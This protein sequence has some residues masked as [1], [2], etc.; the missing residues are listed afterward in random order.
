MK[1]AQFLKKSAISVIALV[2]LMS[3][4]LALGAGGIPPESFPAAD[5]RGYAMMWIES[6]NGPYQVAPYRDHI[7]VVDFHF[8]I[9][10]QGTSGSAGD[11]YS[12]NPQFTEITVVKNIDKTSPALAMLCASGRAIQFVEIKLMRTETWP[13][14]PAPDHYYVFTLDDVVI[15]KFENRMV[16]READGK[17]GHLEE[18]SFRCNRLSFY[19]VDS[20]DTQTWDL[21]RNT[22]Y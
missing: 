17:Y 6:I 13:P 12:S 21:Q 20:G 10:N 3:L 7:K 1:T 16:H 19:D 2:I 9:D 4:C 14:G 8:G 11:R 22:T 5:G 18:L 15:S